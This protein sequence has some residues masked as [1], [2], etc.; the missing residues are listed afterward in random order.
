MKILAVVPARGGSKRIPGKNKRRLGAKTLVQWSIE[1]GQA[2][3]EI[4]DVLVSTDDEEIASLA[5]Q[6]GAMAP[7][8]RPADLATDTASSVDVCLHAL[9]WY[10]NHRGAIDG[11]LLLSPTTPFRNVARMRAGIEMFKE[12]TT[13]TILGVSPA[14]SHPNWCFREEGDILKPFHDG[15]GLHLRSQDLPRAYV[16]NGSFYL[17]HPRLLREARSFYGAE[18]APLIAESAAEA[19]DIDDEWDWLIAE[20]FVGARDKISTNS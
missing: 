18:L 13:R 7:W 2:I 12:N 15:A 8:L 9:D 14:R 20:A 1:A 10:E 17:I 16:V 6:A 5:R 11:V 3:A 4:C 19:L